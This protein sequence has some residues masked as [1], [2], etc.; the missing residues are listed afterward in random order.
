MLKYQNSIENAG[1]IA[2]LFN[3]HLINLLEKFYG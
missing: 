2:R 3:K 1:A